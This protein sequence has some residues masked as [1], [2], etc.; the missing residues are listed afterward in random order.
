MDQD[1]RALVAAAGSSSLTRDS[2]TSTAWQPVSCTKVRCSG[3]KMP[4]SPATRIPLNSASWPAV[5][6]MMRRL[7]YRSTCPRPGTSGQGAVSAVDWPGTAHAW[8]D[9][10]CLS[11]Q[12]GGDHQTRKLDLPSTMQEGAG[13]GPSWQAY[14]QGHLCQACWA[15]HTLKLSRFLLLIPS[16]ALLRSSRSTRSISA[17]LCTS[18]RHCKPTCPPHGWRHQYQTV[19]TNN[20]ACKIT[21]WQPQIAPS[22]IRAAGVCLHTLAAA[23]SR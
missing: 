5:L 12:S 20:L 6:L 3:V 11:Q 15:M 8:P 17:M 16:M 14:G 1:S 21:C 19:R 9:G 7:L 18:T 2:P 4:L 23:L 13:N 10:C 22:S